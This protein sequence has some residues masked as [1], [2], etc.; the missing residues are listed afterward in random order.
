MKIASYC[1]EWGTEVLPAV[2][3]AAKSYVDM[4]QEALNPVGG[5]SGEKDL[6]IATINENQDVIDVCISEL[7]GEWDFTGHKGSWEP[8]SSATCI[9][10]KE[11]MIE[12]VASPNKTTLT[13]DS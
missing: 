8:K 5:C 4:Q 1:T 9:G 11:P 10:K 13:Y 7:M 6:A 2:L 12:R 3:M